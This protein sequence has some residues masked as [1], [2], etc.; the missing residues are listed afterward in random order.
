MFTWLS[1]FFNKA[2]KAFKSFVKIAFPIAK[3]IIIGL[4]KD[5]ALSIV[6][7]LSHSNLSND[8]KRKEAFIRIKS[9]AELKG[10]EVTSS[11]I[12]MAIEMAVQ[13]LKK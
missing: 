13:Y 3:Q 6:E 9:K 11:L 10:I 12:N 7:E 8:E 2:L 5:I 1:N 4:L